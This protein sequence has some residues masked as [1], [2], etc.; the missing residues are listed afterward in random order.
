MGRL[1]RMNGIVI[2]A[3]TVS[4]KPVRIQIITLM[5]AQMLSAILSHSL[6][7]VVMLIFRTRQFV[8]RYFITVHGLVGL[9]SDLYCSQLFSFT[10]TASQVI[11]EFAKDE[12]VQVMRSLRRLRLGIQRLQERNAQDLDV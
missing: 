7:S 6:F 2:S 5:I 1:V 11:Q 8:Y 9:L 10:R 4:A 12:V 3:S